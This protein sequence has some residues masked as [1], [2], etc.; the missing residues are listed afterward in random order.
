MCKYALTG[1]CP[2][3]AAVTFYKVHNGT[4]DL[5]R[6][7]ETHKEGGGETS[8]TMDMKA[9]VSRGAAKAVALRF[10]RTDSNL[11]HVC[12]G[13]VEG[14]MRQAHGNIVSWVYD[15][16]TCPTYTCAM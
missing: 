6:Q 12:K 10:M 8:V 16:P 11:C 4:S 14:E 1:S 9:V 5:E 3:G 2:L 13:N 15:V 7:K